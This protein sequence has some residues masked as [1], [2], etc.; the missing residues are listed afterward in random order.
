MSDKEEILAV[1]EFVNNI[2]NPYSDEYIP[3]TR[4]ERWASINQGMWFLLVH[5][6]E[7][8]EEAP[9]IDYEHM[10]SYFVG[11]SPYHVPRMSKYIN[12]LGAMVFDENTK[13]KETA[14][15]AEYQTATYFGMM[16]VTE[17]EDIDPSGLYRVENGYS[18]WDMNMNMDS[19]YFGSDGFSGLIEVLYDPR[20]IESVVLC[21]NWSTRN[22]AYT[23]WGIV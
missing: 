20:F 22:E 14:V 8:R 5:D 6:K 9:L 16:S 15:D 3:M 12:G 18:L 11:R 17:V 19:L 1:I 4:H 7:L 21:E 23:Q 13:V 10:T 2:D